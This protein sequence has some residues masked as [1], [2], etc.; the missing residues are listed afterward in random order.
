MRVQTWAEQDAEKRRWVAYMFERGRR[1]GADPEE[2]A[3]LADYLPQPD[4][5]ELEEKQAARGRGEFSR[6]VARMSPAQVDRELASLGYAFC[7]RSTSVG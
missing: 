5:R 4:L 1:S 6:E 3:R 2:L 7:N